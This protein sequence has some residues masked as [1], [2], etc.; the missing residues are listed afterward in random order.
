[1]QVRA[2]KWSPRGAGGLHAVSMA[3]LLAGALPAAA[4]RSAQARL[5]VEQRQIHAA[6]VCNAG[7]TY[8]QDKSNGAA[9]QG[10]ARCET[11]RIVCKALSSATSSPQSYKLTTS[12]Y[13][14]ISSNFTPLFVV[15]STDS[16]QRTHASAPDS[17]RTCS[18]T[19]VRICYFRMD[20]RA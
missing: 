3:A 18:G 8:V 12:I 16:F 19:K 9:S 10:A 4:Q 20:C 13:V 1:M 5:M 17:R 7:A 2:R 14:I 15:R 6:R 11:D